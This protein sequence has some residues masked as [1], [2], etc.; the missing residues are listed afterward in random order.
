M[1]GRQADTGVDGMQPRNLGLVV[2]RGPN[3]V[4]ISPT[5]G[6]AGEIPFPSLCPEV[7]QCGQQ[8][9][10]LQKSRTRSHSFAKVT[11]I[12][13]RDKYTTAECK[14]Y[15]LE[16]LVVEESNSYWLIVILLNR[17]SPGAED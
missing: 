9:S 5:D 3:V 14:K 17:G 1:T 7:V 13:E 12:D 8:C 16:S 10:F 4:L 6:S 15:N 2:L 11:R